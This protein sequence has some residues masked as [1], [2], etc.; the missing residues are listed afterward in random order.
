MPKSR[1]T[2]Y[3]RKYRIVRLIG[4]GRDGVFRRVIEGMD[5]V[6]KIEKT[7]TYAEDRPVTP[8]K[9]NRV[10]VLET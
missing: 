7:K 9:M 5:V 2:S 3:R 6:K 1:R 10:T 8:V 4:T